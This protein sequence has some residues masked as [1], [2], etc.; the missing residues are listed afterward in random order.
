MNRLCVAVCLRVPF[1]CRTVTGL[2]CG[3]HFIKSLNASQP[4]SCKII[5][6]NCLIVSNLRKHL[7]A[8]II[9]LAVVAG[10]L[11]RATL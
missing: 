4:L 11:R 2:R 10:R 6:F 1:F 3:G 5:C 8:I 7:L 9:L